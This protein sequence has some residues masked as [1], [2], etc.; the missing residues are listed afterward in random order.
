MRGQ[1]RSPTTIWLLSLVTGGIYGLYWWYTMGEELAGALDLEEG[2]L[3]PGRDI[4]FGS[5][6]FLYLFWLPL[7]YGRLID[8]LVATV[9]LP[10]RRGR[11]VRY[12]LGMFLCQYGYAMMQ[13]DLNEIWDAMALAETAGR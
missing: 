9:D 6:C 11:G 4:L 2:V 1:R 3:D 12:L 8:S 10:P 7:R 5:L 13:T